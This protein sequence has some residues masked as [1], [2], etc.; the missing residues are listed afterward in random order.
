MSHIRFIGVLNMFTRQVFVT[1]QLRKR[2][3]RPIQFPQKILNR[4]ES[5]N[6]DIFTPSELLLSRFM[7][8]SRKHQFR[9][10]I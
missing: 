9:G 1:D 2:L 8:T 3:R 5:D 10:K 4:T 7:K 6:C